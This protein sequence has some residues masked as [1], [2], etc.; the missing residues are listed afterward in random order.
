[1]CV[2]EM[3]NGM[4]DTMMMKALQFGIEIET[5][6]ALPVRLAWAVQTVV[7]GTVEFDDYEDAWRVAD[8][9][10]RIWRVD[11]DA[12]L[13]DD[14]YSGEIV[15]PVLGYEDLEQLQD[16][17][18]AVRRAGARADSSTGIHVHVGGDRIDV[19][20]ITNLVKFMHKQEHLLEHVFAAHQQRRRYC[21]PIDSAFLQRLESRR[22]Q[23]MRELRETWYGDDT[24]QATRYHESRY[25]GLN[26]NSFFF[27]RS[28]EFRYFNGTLHAGEVKAYVQ[29]VLALTANAITA[30]S[31]SSK[32][33]A[34]NPATAKYDFRVVLLR[35][36]LIGDEFKTARLHLTKALAGSAAWKHA[37]RDASIADASASAGD[38]ANVRAAA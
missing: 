38:V 1:M 37:R 16:V 4:T 30:K 18:R 10:G 27:R 6:G 36:G 5:V 28:I 19:K 23:T 21:V 29:L 8:A 7:G 34:F 14:E 17:I 32:R 22:P 25:R 15:S 3:S 35:L 26:L 13:S 12:S 24:T 11:P 2:F 31:A 9:R 33:R 20:A